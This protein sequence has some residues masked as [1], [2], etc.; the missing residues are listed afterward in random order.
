MNFHHKKT[1]RDIDV[2]N[3][4]VLVRCDFNV[5]HNEKTGEILD[6]TRIAA[7]LP[8][9]RYLLDKGASVILCSHFGRPKGVW[10]EEFSLSIAGAH[11]QEL[12]GQPVTL[13]KD[14]L[15][16][17][18]KRAANE[19]QSGEILLIENLRFRPEEEANDP[20][21][22]KE[23]ASLAD[24]LVFDAFGVAHRKHASTYGVSNY[25]PC[26]AGLLVEKELDI[27]GRALTEPKRPLTAIL[28]GSKVSDKIGVILNLLNIADTIII[29]GGMSY[30]FQCAKGGTI[31]NSLVETDRI[32]F[33]RDM[34]ALAKEKNVEILLPIDDLAAN[35]FSSN[36]TPVLVDSMNI[37]DNL[38]GLDI[39]PKTIDLFSNSIKQSSTVI[40]NG[41]MG[42]FEF[43]S[44]SN[45]TRAVAQTLANMNE[46]ITIIGG[47]DS[48][49]AIEQMGYASKMTHI[50]TGGGASLKFLEGQSLPGIACLQDIT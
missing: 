39:G 3:K 44:F 16:E 35:E 49:S 30:T 19:L 29:G 45:G 5:P 20:N 18:C 13:T 14:V 28:G 11:L 43:A 6:D 1:V 31:G 48:A 21:F 9:I 24:Y 26:V 47:G 42:V 27:M 38:M 33:A 40:W 4:K 50:S 17:D 7:S 25:L 12:L 41:P 2:N 34:L 23:L 32:D 8:T 37:P 22:S 15:G 46:A 10:L 36:A